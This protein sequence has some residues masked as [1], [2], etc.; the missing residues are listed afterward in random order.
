MSLNKLQKGDYL[1][2]DLI[3]QFV[4]LNYDTEA[5]KENARCRL[6]WLKRYL[7]DIGKDITEMGK[8]EIIAFKP[9]IKKQKGRHGKQ[10]KAS[11][12]RM[13]ISTIKCMFE[14]LETLDI[15]N[16]FKEIPSRVLKRLKP[17]AKKDRVPRELSSEEIKKI[18]DWLQ[19][20]ADEDAYLAC[21][22]SF[23]TGTRLAE[24]LK[25]KAKNIRNREGHVVIFIRHAKG[26][27]ERACILGVPVKKPNGVV[28]SKVIKRLNEEVKRKVLEKKKAAEGYLFGDEM[29]RRRL[30]YRIQK[31][32]QRLS[33]EEDIDIHF[34]SFRANYGAK[35]LRARIPLEYVSKQLGHKTTKTTETYYARV[36]D[37]FTLSFMKDRI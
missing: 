19:D 30:R 20:R 25:I 18:F 28:S 17:E 29:E 6:V 32:L 13:I 16:P 10:L 31:D 23:A 4:E 3:E 22:I 1:L 7:K 5:S 2:D 14:F 11:Y 21:L 26:F 35:A 37:E 27:R 8:K 15:D 36:K 34:H 9:W 12:I 24:T 33:N